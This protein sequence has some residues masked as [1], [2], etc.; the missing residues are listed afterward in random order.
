MNPGP[1]PRC[2]CGEC[3]LCRHREQ[4]KQHNARRKE[5][6]QNE[7]NDEQLDRIMTLYFLRKGWDKPR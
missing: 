1:K 4:A 7:P 5:N 6:P 3:R 2:I